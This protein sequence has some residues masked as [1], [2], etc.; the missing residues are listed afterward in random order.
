MIYITPQSHKELVT[1]KKKLISLDGKE[2][3]S[4]IKGVPILLP[5]NTNPDWNRELLEIIFWEHPE[6]IKKIYSE[7]ESSNNVDWNEVYVKHIKAFY[8]TKED[9]LKVFESYKQRETT[10]WIA[11]DKSGNI[12]KSQIKSFRKFNKKSVGKKKN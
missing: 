8:C 9:L 5:E 3:Y 1:N 10:C 11:G 6:E 4:V 2:S 12:T 7:I